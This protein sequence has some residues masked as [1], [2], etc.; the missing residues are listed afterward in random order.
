M[1]MDAQQ[2]CTSIRVGATPL[3]NHMDVFSPY[4][5]HLQPSSS[6]FVSVVIAGQLVLLM[7]ARP[8][9]M[10]VRDR[11]AGRKRLPWEEPEA[12]ANG[13]RQLRILKHTVLACLSRDPVNRPTAQRLLRSWNRIFDTFSTG[14]GGVGTTT[15]VL[16]GRQ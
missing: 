1:L 10:Q 9:C 12:V 4:F 8:E 11:I 13:H 15:N 14:S 5:N 16:A 3:K 6:P 2:Q 7:Q